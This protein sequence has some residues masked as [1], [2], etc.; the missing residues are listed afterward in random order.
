MTIAPRTIDEYL[1]R[2][3]PDK[4][5][6]LQALRETVRAAAPDAEECISYQMPAFRLNGMLVW[7]GAGVNHCAFYPGATV[8]AFK[9]ELSGF[10]TSKGTIRFQPDTPLP[11]ALVRRIVLARIEQNSQRRAARAPSRGRAA[12]SVGSVARS[13]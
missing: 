8:A 7:F 9:D 11:T 3:S 6:A 1:D 2:V 5:A 10:A 4:R 12:P 13:G